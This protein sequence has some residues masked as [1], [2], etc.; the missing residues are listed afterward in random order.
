LED[1]WWLNLIGQHGM[2]RRDQIGKESR[3]AVSVR[4]VVN[5]D[6]LDQHSGWI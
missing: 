3:L 1:E 6:A 2:D 4:H 5:R